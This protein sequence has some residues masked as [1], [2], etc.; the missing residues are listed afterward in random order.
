MY[1][2]NRGIRWLFCFLMGAVQLPCIVAAVHADEIE[3]GDAAVKTDINLGT[4]DGLTVWIEHLRE[5]ESGD[6][7][8]T[9]VTAHWRTDT[10]REG[11]QALYK[12]ISVGDIAVSRNGRRI[13]LH[14]AGNRYQSEGLQMRIPFVWNGRTNAFVEQPATEY[15]PNEEMVLQLE[16]LLTA[17]RFVEARSLA[18]R[19]GVSP[20]GG[21]TFQTERLFM[22]FLKAMHRKAMQLYRSE[23]KAAAAA[24]VHTLF[25]QPPVCDGQREHLDSQFYLDASRFSR[26]GENRCFFHIAASPQNIQ[27]INDCAFIMAQAALDLFA[28]D[29]LTQVV[30]HAPERTVAWL[31]LADTEWHLHMASARERYLK[32]IE[33]MTAK[34]RKS[35][36]PKRAYE[37]VSGSE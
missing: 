4:E 17:H 21:H 7:S 32:Y 1:N 15:D 2:L 29:L 22:L 5:W 20:N 35:Q 3:F 19:I 9:R 34:N 10:G 33:M 16:K 12:G 37:R 25:A 6:Y 27:M 31:N 28:L 36:I 26:W 14:M 18:A 30:H 11:A 13:T 8:H 24:L 23:N